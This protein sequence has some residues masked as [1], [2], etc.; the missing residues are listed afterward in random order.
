VAAAAV[1]LAILPLV[2]LPLPAASAGQA[3]AG[4]RQAF[5]SLRLAS[6][7]DVLVIPDL[8]Y[9][10]SWQ[11]E[12]GV[13]GSMV[14]GGAIIAPGPSRQATSYIYTRRPTAKYLDALYL[15][16][17]GRPAPSPAQLRADL[18][19]WHPAAIVV[20]ATRASRL[21]RYLAEKFGPPTIEVGD[22]LAWQHPVLQTKPGR[23]AA[24]RREVIRTCLAWRR[25]SSPA[26]QGSS[27]RTS[28]SGCWLTAAR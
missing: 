17:P 8:E 19:Y 5:A 3:P 13:P 7:A 6:S 4:W 28:A 11:A 10:M 15:G 26:E 18:A 24:L 25:S 20:V 2:P 16:R 27:A 14:G 12:T 21:G 9:G 1:V 22:M 23:L